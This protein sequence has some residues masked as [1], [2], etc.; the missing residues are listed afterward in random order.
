V[1]PPTSSEGTVLHVADTGNHSIQMFALSAFAVE[2]DS[3]GSIK[4]RY[5]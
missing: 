3:W 1:A 5:R 2:P 4:A